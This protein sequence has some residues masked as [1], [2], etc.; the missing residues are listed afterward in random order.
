[1]FETPMRLD[2]RNVPHSTKME[3]GLVSTVSITSADT[4]ITHLEHVQVYVYVECSRRG[5]VAIDLVSPTGVSSSLLPARRSDYKS[6]NL[7]WTMMT[8][9]H[10]DEQP[11]GEWKLYV[12]NSATLSNKATLVKWKLILYGTSSGVSCPPGTVMG[13]GAS[14]VACDTECSSLGCKGEG[15]DQCIACD[16]YKH[17]GTCVKS[18]L[19]VGMRNPDALNGECQPCHPECKGMCGCAGLLYL[20]FRPV[21]LRTPSFVFAFRVLLIFLFSFL[22][23]CPLTCS[24]GGCYGSEASEC[25]ECAHAA[26]TLGTLRFCLAQCPSN[27]YANEDGICTT[28]AGYASLGYMCNLFTNCVAAANVQPAMGQVLQIA[29]SVLTTARATTHASKRVLQVW[30]MLTVQ[31]SA[32]DTARHV[33]K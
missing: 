7:D 25:H 4:A 33:C 17:D 15:A 8:L 29:M 22:S 14:C 9:R 16:H 18:C 10:W 31:S 26:Q 2:N 28:C 30:H 5:D 32:H 1:M 24:T 27:M 23:V 6:E 21:P 11:L 12:R 20:Y 19:D 13:E 3:D